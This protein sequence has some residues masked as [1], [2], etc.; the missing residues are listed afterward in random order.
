M[1]K[2][3]LCLL[4]FSFILSFG[5]SKDMD[6]KVLKLSNGIPVYYIENTENQIDS[7][8][9]SVEGSIRYFTPE[10]S[11][12]EQVL[13]SMMTRG[14]KKYA[15]DDIQSYIYKTSSSFSS[16]SDENQSC[17]Y[18]N[19][20]DDYFDTSLDIL[21]DGFMNPVFAESEY[22]KM[23][24]EVRQNIQV[25][26]NDPYSMGFYYGTRII[27]KGTLLE[28]SANVLDTS[29]ENLSLDLIKKYYKSVIDSSRIKIFVV[30]KQ[31]SNV[32]ISKL[33]SS[34]GKIKPLKTKRNKLA[35]GPLTIN[36]KPLVLTHP[37]AGGTGFIYRTY[38]APSQNAKDYCAY[39]ISS[40]IYSD[41]MHNVIRAKYGICYGAFDQC[42]G[43]LSNIGIN[44][45][46]RCSD[47]TK[48]KEALEEVKSIMKEGKTI[49]S[50]NPDGTFVFIPISEIIESKKNQLINSM[51]SS[52]ATTNG[53]LNRMLRSYYLYGNPT[54]INKNLEKIQA[55]TEQ[56]IIDAFNKY[57][58]STNEFWFAVVG[59][60]AENTAQEIL[61]K[62]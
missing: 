58:L 29:V 57:N 53:L 20:I 9:I 30:A 38:S 5:F 8:C 1:K 60:E 43:G 54:E 62:M 14:S 42:S 59:L 16:G 11:G 50:T 13:F 15:Y 45:I 23:M 36:N 25:Q 34:I 35:L 40:M 24:T 56:D 31:P 37:S 22:N 39:T 2:R 55:V 4:V 41:L 52:Q 46:Y 32:V 51:Y 17:V 49:K 19:C 10:Q 7:V 44:V 61:E 48:I 47:M 18:M 3:F 6:V 21:I 27:Y 26:L 28:T 12:L 33:N